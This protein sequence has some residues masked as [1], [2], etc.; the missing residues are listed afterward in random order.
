MPPSS[1]RQLGKFA[2]VRRIAAVF[3]FDVSALELSPEAIHAAGLIFLR[4]VHW[5]PAQVRS[6][7]ANHRAL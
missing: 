4:S 2:V 5:S 1:A 7:V 3:I 6:F